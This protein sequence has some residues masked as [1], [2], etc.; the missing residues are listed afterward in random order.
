MIPPRKALLLGSALTLLV[1]PITN[2]QTDIRLSGG[3]TQTASNQAGGNQGVRSAANAGVGNTNRAM[4]DSQT[5][6]QISV[7][8]FAIFPRFNDNGRNVG[9]CL[10]DWRRN[11]NVGR[12]GAGEDMPR[13]RN[14][15]RADF[16]MMII[17]RNAPGNNGEATPDTG[18]SCIKAGRERNP[19]F[20][21]EI[22]HNL[23]ALHSHANTLAKTSRNQLPRTVTT[24]VG[25]RG[26]GYGPII[27]RYSN[28]NLRYL[29]ARTGTSSRKNALRMNSARVSRSRLR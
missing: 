10:G 22:G 15:T 17:R 5:N 29:G 28:P 21:H 3:F 4:R 24:L 25:S 2:A 20:P 8:W 26:R 23:S 19:T 11:R 18:F 1:A 9:A 6:T 16:M 14:R 13:L 7:G 27:N 12:T